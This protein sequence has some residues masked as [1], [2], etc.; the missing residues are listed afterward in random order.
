MIIM[1]F[2]PNTAPNICLRTENIWL[3]RSNKKQMEKRWARTILGQL[4]LELQRLILDPLK[5]PLGR[6]LHGPHLVARGRPRQ[7]RLLLQLPLRL[8]GHLPRELL[9]KHDALPLLERPA[10]V[11]RDVEVL[12]E[13]EVHLLRGLAQS[14]EEDLG[15][16]RVARVHDRASVSHPRVVL[17]AVVHERERRHAVLVI[18]RGV[19]D[20]V[21]IVL[22]VQVIIVVIDEVG[23]ILRILVEFLHGIA[24]EELSVGLLDAPVELAEELPGG[25]LREEVH[26]TG[27]DVEELVLAGGDVPPSVPQLR[28]ERLNELL[29]RGDGV[30]SVVR[31]LG[32]ARHVRY[33]ALVELSHDVVLEDVTAFD[34][35]SGFV[36]LAVARVDADDV[37]EAVGIRDA[38]REGK[39]ALFEQARADGRAVGGVGGRDRGEGGVVGAGEGGRECREGEG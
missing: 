35:T 16:L 17:P 38:L 34:L 25:G 27:E 3:K 26:L 9:P 39:A 30:R 15:Q 23:R 8:Y 31:L 1:M 29:L 7:Y 13:V 33:G 11:V 2:T 18:V 20:D 28:V 36:L 21:P 4:L 19:I 5:R 12:I 22:I 24:R 6:L 32:D 37:R 14:R 10:R